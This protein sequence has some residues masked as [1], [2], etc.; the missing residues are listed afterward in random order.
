MCLPYTVASQ[1]RKGTVPANKPEKPSKRTDQL[2]E[3]TFADAV[4][5]FLLERYED[6]REG[7]AKAYGL[8]PKSAAI[9]Y[10]LAETLHKLNRT[11]EAIP[12]AEGAIILEPKN[13][14]YYLLLGELYRKELKLDKA[15]RTYELML[16]QIPATKEYHFDLAA[17]YLYMGKYKEALMHLNLFE[18]Y[19]GLSEDV[20]KQ[21]Q[22]IYLRQNKLDKAVDEGSKLIKAYPGD[23]KYVLAQAEMLLSN[24][25]TAE[26][27]KILENLLKENSRNAI[28]HLLLHNLYKAEGK[29]EAAQKSLEQA[30]EDP[31]LNVEQKI[32]IIATFLTQQTQENLQTAR[33][34]TERI[35]KVH[36]DDPRALGLMGDILYTL[37]QKK[38]ARSAYL[39]ALEKDGNNFNM[40]RQVIV[41]DYELQLFDSMI[42]H[43][44]KAVELFPTQ[45]LL[46]FF[47]GTGEVIQKKYKD[48]SA[49]LEEAKT[50]TKT[51]PDIYLQVMAQLG[52]VYHYL[53][54]YTKSDAAYEEVL[55]KDPE[56]AIALNNYAYFLSLRGEKLQ[57]A[58]EMSGGLVKKE[59]DN[60]TYLDTYGWIL[61]KL[62]EF[63]QA[64]EYLE[65]AVSN[66]GGNGVI[67][68]HLGDVYFK[69]GRVEQ[70]LELWQKA[71][72]AGDASDLLDKKLADKKL[73]E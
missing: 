47:K 23:R 10:K 46:W 5:Y 44:G 36:P 40:W 52:D 3:A 63:E 32:N 41:I 16:K 70:A 73:Y 71:K 24:N 42:L 49:S 55:R 34:L 51:T 20:V 60:A 50:L 38:E 15:T 18:S 43:A 37:N 54:E 35:L 68:E 66:D 30:F 7:F 25:K 22:Y 33:A 21:R 61:Y 14:Y 9:H 45:G 6:A 65:K 39:S 48:A 59:P 64:K 26:A 19:F 29:P 28:A 53:Q 69:L 4:K 12:Y 72:K 13:K 1:S 56:N 67:L 8:D 62:G 27:K 57:K 31:D 17:L 58:K 2:L 11:A